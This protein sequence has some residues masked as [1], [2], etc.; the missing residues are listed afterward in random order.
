MSW[1]EG[2]RITVCIPFQKWVTVAIWKL[3][4]SELRT[5]SLHFWVV[6][7]TMLNYVYEFCYVVI[8]VLLP[9]QIVWPDSDMLVE[10]ATVLQNLWSTTM[11]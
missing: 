7:S 2:T 10:K 4:S 1:G 9:V 11:F 3:A 8:M 6:L 5:I